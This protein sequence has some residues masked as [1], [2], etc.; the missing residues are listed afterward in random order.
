MFS[1]KKGYGHSFDN[2]TLRYE[3]NRK[4]TSFKSYFYAGSNG[5][6][7]EPASCM[8]STFYLEGSAQKKN[9]W[10]NWVYKNN[11]TP[12]T[13]LSGTWSFQFKLVEYNNPY[14]YYYLNTISNPDNNMS[15]LYYNFTQ[16]VNNTSYFKFTCEPD[17]WF[18]ASTGWLMDE[19]NV[20]NY[21]FRMKA[22]NYSDF[23]HTD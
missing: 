12:I 17:G 16:S 11:Y 5:V 9:I 22:E 14:N 8:L 10:G 19:I 21:N 6:Y 23:V 20:Y 18:C 2:Y 4:R 7:Y 15:P 13:E 3:S 1:N